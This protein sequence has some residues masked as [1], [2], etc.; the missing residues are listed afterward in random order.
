MSSNENWSM[1]VEF[2]SAKEYVASVHNFSLLWNTLIK[3]FF[4]LFGYFIYSDK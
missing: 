2:G 4:S 1:L 3:S